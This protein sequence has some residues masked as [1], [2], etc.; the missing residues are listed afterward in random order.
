LSGNGGFTRSSPML[1][2]EDVDVSF[3]GVLALARVS[4]NLAQGSI[5]ALI[6]PNGAGKTT[7]INVVAGIYRSQHG[8]VFF[9]GEEVGGC[10]PHKM[11][12]LGL[13]RTFQ[14]LQIFEN[15]TVLENVMVGLHAR[16]KNEFACSMFHLRGFREE[17]KEIEERA[18]EALRFFRLES[19]GHLLASSLSFGQQK[20]LEMARAFAPRPRLMLLDEPVA[21][22]NM[23]ETG[24]I[25]S[26]ICD[27][28]SQGITVLLVEHD[29]NLVM[30]ISDK[31]VV[32][33]YGS[34]I[35]EGNPQEIQKDEQVLAA[36][37]GGAA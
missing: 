2:V 6:G 11:A 36:Y 5:T 17:E 26:L 14:N 8:K 12:A 32:L 30:S 1:A 37:L 34:K 31:V 20:R 16:T 27:M 23:T 4:F 21:G 10:P 3:G 29:M 25:A 19:K 22:L 7:M 28:R 33:N 15:M 35:A 24:E 9:A 13:T 18:W